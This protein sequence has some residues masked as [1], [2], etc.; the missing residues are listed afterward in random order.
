MNRKVGIGPEQ[1]ADRR[2]FFEIHWAG[3]EPTLPIGLAVVETG[4]QFAWLTFTDA[5]GL[6][7]TKIK[8]KESAAERQD[9]AAAAAKDQRANR[10][11]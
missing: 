7:G 9:R 11:R 10:L 5:L 6:A 2:A 3:D 4:P 1:F 8:R